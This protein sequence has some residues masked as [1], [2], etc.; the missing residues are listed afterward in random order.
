MLKLVPCATS[1]MAATL[2][3]SAPAARGAADVVASIPERF[4]PEAGDTTEVPDFQR[5]VVPLMGKL[6]CNGRSCHGSFQGQG[7]FR[8]SLFGYDFKMDHENLTA[9]DEPRVNLDSP[10]DSLILKKPTGDELVHGGGH[11]MDVGSWKY[12]VF[13][14]WIEG[15]AKPVAEDAATLDRLEITPSEMV[16]AVAGETVQLRVVAKW[17]D[18]TREDVTPLCRFQTNNSQ[19]AEITQDGL[20]TA[21]EP[22]DTHVVVF[23]DAGVV[24]VPVMRPVSDLAG[25]NYPDVPT[26]TKV[27]ELVIAKLRKLGIVPSDLADDAEFLRRVRLDLTGTLPS[28]REVEAFLADSSADKRSRKIDELLETPAYAAWWTTRLCDWTGNS[29]DQLNNVTPQRNQAS[30]D[31]YDWI[32]QRVEQNVPYD[33]LAAGIVLA[34]SRDEGE[35]FRDYCKTMTEIYGGESDETFADRDS[36]PHYWARR[37]F[38]RPDERAIGFAYTFLGIR[39]QCAQCHKH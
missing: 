23:Y 18:G 28:P 37:N 22:G 2:L 12:R 27:D 24:P 6:G 36:M 17:S 25:K 14:K 5:H 39:I 29:D 4:A 19:V 34:A 33:E 8:L 31:W 7:G 15:G 26:P 9:G 13:R 21:L 32:D 3:I 10:T 38:R 11:R 1:L 35:S 30:Q 16:F 20:V